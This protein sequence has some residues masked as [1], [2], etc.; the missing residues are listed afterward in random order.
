[1]GTARSPNRPQRNARLSVPEATTLKQL[2]RVA[3]PRPAGLPRLRL[4]CGRFRRRG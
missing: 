2:P 4:S 1:L 3:F